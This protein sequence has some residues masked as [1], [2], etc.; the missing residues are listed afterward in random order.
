MDILSHNDF[1]SV[2]EKGGKYVRH[3]NSGS[4]TNA[5]LC[6]SDIVIYVGNRGSGKSTLILNRGLKNVSNRHYR[7]IYFRKQIKDSQT[8]GGIADASRRIFSQFGDYKESQQ[9]MRWDFESGAKIVFGN[10]SAPEKEFAEAVQGIEY[11]DAFIDEITQI[12]EDR[13]NAILSNI[14]NTSGHIGQLYGTCN[15]DADSWIA[16]LISWWWDNDTGYHIPERD[17]L[18]RY[19]FQYGD[20][21]KEAIWGDTR[22]EVYSLAKEYIDPYWD[23]NM[24]KYGSKLDL[25]L[26]LTVF[27]GKMYEN[28]S[29]MS[30]GGVSYMGKLLKGSNEMKN[31][32]VRPCWRKID[33]G[34]GL[35]TE[36]DM[37]RMFNNSHQTT[38][39]RYASMDISGEGS[40]KTVIF[41]WDGL[42]ISNIYAVQ[43]MQAKNLL[44]FT[45][46]T[47]ALEGVTDQNFAYDGV[48]VGY[49]FSGFFDNAKKVIS[50]AKVSDN[51][52]VKDFN[53]R[54]LRLYANTVSELSGRLVD[55]IKNF[56]GI[57]ECGISIN[58]ELLHRKFFGKTLQEH[59]THESK[60][61]RW[62]NDKDGIRQ[63]IDK[64]ETKRIIGHS[65]D[66]IKALI[67][68][69][70]F[71][72]SVVNFT[73][74]EEKNISKFSSFF[75]NY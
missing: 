60:A 30:S 69:F 18:Q 38:G 31:R 19:F 71:E 51:A 66:F 29:L 59:L 40:D 33:Y 67:Y 6:K 12:S 57:G 28:E 9:L 7:S 35:L 37:S 55:T 23:Q 65:A 26:S 22:E 45:I 20:N 73:P 11:Y 13:F 49:A 4:Q 64:K 16:D 24:A 21:I 34:D 42:H 72:L 8:V 63:L 14:R 46:R 54:E 36:E 25:I 2:K 47:L 44:E 1:L 32:Y 48:G 62:R 41:I 70:I 17:G 3:L 75:M 58:P 10:Y 56:N 5:Y 27:E 52:I 53:D 74:L 50:N 68:R 15:A 43:G 61:I 39:T